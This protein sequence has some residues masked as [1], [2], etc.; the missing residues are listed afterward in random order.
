MICSAIK[1]QEWNGTDLCRTIQQPSNIRLYKNK[2]VPKGTA[3]C[4]CDAVFRKTDNSKP[5][6][7]VNNIKK[8]IMLKN[9][10]TQL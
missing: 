9:N 1:L 8:I 7:T 10:I 2:L 5:F 3:K 4:T 6:A